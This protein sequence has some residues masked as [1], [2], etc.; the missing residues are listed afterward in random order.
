MLR[1]TYFLYFFTALLIQTCTN[2]QEMSPD[3][4][5]PT[6]EQKIVVRK[7][8]IGNRI[9]DAFA[10][11]KTYVT[12]NIQKIVDKTTK[13]Y[14]EPKVIVIRNHTRL[15]RWMFNKNFRKDKSK[16]DIL[17]HTFHPIANYFIERYGKKEAYNSGKFS[18]IKYSLQ[19]QI[20]YPNGKKKNVVFSITKDHKDRWY[21]REIKFHNPKKLRVSSDTFEPKIM[22]YKFGNK[23]AVRTIVYFENSSWIKIYDAANDVTLYLMKQ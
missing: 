2:A 17:Y 15:K 22:H 14:P 19:G 16:K 9:Q 21:H 11:A 20:R 3:T 5:N 8:P 10:T 1:H 4:A 7:K 23:G 12:E 18:G 13:K 6:P